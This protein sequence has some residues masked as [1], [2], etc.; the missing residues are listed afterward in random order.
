MQ[1]LL[2]FVM[3]LEVNWTE[4][5]VLLTPVGC[6]VPIDTRGNIC[7]FQPLLT[8]WPMDTPWVHFPAVSH[9]WITPSRKVTLGDLTPYYFG[10]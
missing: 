10:D 7:T 5:A 6:F 4:V 2:L 9:R 8:D 1:P 3:R